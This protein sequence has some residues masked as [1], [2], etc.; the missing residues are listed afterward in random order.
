MPRYFFDV[1]DGRDPTDDVGVECPSLA[2]ALELAFKAMQD[3]F[4]DERAAGR[5]RE[6]SI[7]V[8]DQRG[9]CFFLIELAWRF[10]W[11]GGQVA[12]SDPE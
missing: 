12:A 1:S 9:R 2:A 11:V 4:R 8:R 10:Q 6:I 7:S 5:S 3:A